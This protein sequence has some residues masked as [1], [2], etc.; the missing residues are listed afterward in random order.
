MRKSYLIIFWPT[1]ILIRVCVYYTSMKPGHYKIYGTKYDSF[2]VVPGQGF[3]QT[4]K[5]GQMIY[6]HTDDALYVKYVYTIGSY[7]G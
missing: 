2:G 1:M 4:A 5:F 6:A 3:E 7:M